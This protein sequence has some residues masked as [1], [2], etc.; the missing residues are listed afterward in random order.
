MKILVLDGHTR[1]ALPFVRSLG[2]AG[3]EVILGSSKSFFSS[4]YSK[5]SSGYVKLPDPSKSGFEK[6]IE[7]V[8][9]YCSKNLV[10][11]LIPLEED[12]T[13]ALIKFQ[14]VL[15]SVSSFIVPS[16]RSFEIAI[17]KWKTYTF[18]SDIKIPVPKT[19]LLS[20]FKHT[21][22]SSI[23]FPIIL[24]PRIGKG[25]MGVKKF[26]SKEDFHDFLREFDQAEKSNYILQDL[27]SKRW[28][29]MG[30]SYLYDNN[31]KCIAGFVHLRIREYPVSGG[32]STLCVSVRNDLI[33]NA[34]KRILDALNWKGFAMVEFK[35]D[36]ENYNYVVLEINPRTWGSIVLPIFCGVDFPT[37]Y[38]KACT[39]QLVELKPD[40]P[41]GK[42]MRWLIPG[43]MLHFIR[44]PST[45]I[46]SNPQFLKFFDKNTKYYILDKDDPFP[47]VVFVAEL[48]RDLFSKK[49]WM[50]IRRR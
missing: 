30:A 34:G 44:K 25:S 43:D 5:Y 17:D 6:F 4:R 41:E 22:I 24:K 48:I 14:D 8:L 46:K 45:L 13:M 7:V 38:V 42:Y 33:L 50:K 10:S 1:K 15:R 47:A 31:G 49:S 21:D 40:Y 39:N 19:A 16:M 20:D 28:K 11:V 26:L 32:P 2:K 36:I 18:L 29:G 3:Y 12:S 27:I 23:N 9:N 35:V 37:L